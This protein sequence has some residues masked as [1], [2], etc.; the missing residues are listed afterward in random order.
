M[1]TVR[2]LDVR[3]NGLH[4]HGAECGD[5]PPVLLVHG[6]LGTW[7]YLRDTMQALAARDLRAIAFDLPGFGGSQRLTH[8]TLEA[9]G[10]LMLAGARAVGAPRA[11]V[12]GHSL[13]AAVAALA[14]R[15]RPDAVE[16]LVLVGACGLSPASQ[17]PIWGRRHLL[18]V[19]EA[20][21]AALPVWER[22]A[23]EWPLARRA[24][25]RFVAF[26]GRRISPEQTRVLLRGARQARQAREAIETLAH[27]VLLADLHGLPLPLSAV[28]GALDRVAPIA[29][30]A[31][32]AGVRPDARIELLPGLGH[33]PMLEA[34]DAFDAAI[35]RSLGP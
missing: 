35:A 10:D 11:V 24:M 23:S 1:A 20:A 7:R 2:E 15:A 29:D 26:D 8:W 27:R 3:A 19:G 30:A 22:P 31:A 32:L 34:Q 5:G 4:L 9:A 21:L 16:R 25:F 17:W 28:W 6:L 12:V 14:A 18:P 33:A 13:G